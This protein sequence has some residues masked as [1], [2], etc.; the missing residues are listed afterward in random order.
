M[1]ALTYNPR[2]AF[3]PFHNRPH[4]W[5]NLVTHRRA[6]KTVALVNDIILS[7]RTPIRHPD[8]QYAYIGPT[9]TQAKR[10][11]W[12]YLKNYSAPYWTKPPS[13]SELKVTLTNNSVVY[14]LGADNADSLRG[15]YLDG[16]MGDEYAL[17]RP[18]VFSQV[19]RPALS[20]RHGWGVFASTPRGKN[21][22]WDILKKARGNPRDW[23]NLILKASTSGL[24]P[25][26]EIEELI[27]DMDAEEFAQEYECSFDSALKGAIY[28]SEVNH[29]FL[30]QRLRPN[31]F[32]P[33]LPTHFTYDLGF[34]DAMVRIAYQVPP[35]QGKV[36]I[37]N[38][39]AITGKDIFWHIDELYAFPGK[40]GTVFLPHDARARNL[41]T[42]KSIVEQ[43]IEQGITPQMVPAHHVHDGIA[44]TRR[45]WPLLIVDSTPLDPLEPDGDTHTSDFIE[46]AK[47]YHRE[48]DDKTMMFK[49]QPHHDWSSDYMDALRYVAMSLPEDFVFARSSDNALES[50]PK[51]W[52][53]A[54]GYNLETL[55]LDSAA[56]RAAQRTMP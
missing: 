7:A 9:Y 21:L 18:S 20:D 56:S 1:A 23:F 26:R 42:G 40:M 45:L 28:A 39:T 37:V 50:A 29:L 38:V 33:S 3:I 52:R 6:G 32:D 47:Q 55:H 10:I 19:I 25:K 30:S 34:T 41:Q 36:H 31:L 27:R 46:A 11:A 8:P 24:M 4:R 35:L 13:E 22:F 51:V 54:L 49:D 12:G 16:F 15:M 5:A 53:P 44:A 2:E 48:W 14:C 17:W 43:F